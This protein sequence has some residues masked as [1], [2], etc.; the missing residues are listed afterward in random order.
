MFTIT[1]TLDD[2]QQDEELTT[3]S[4]EITDNNKNRT[5]RTNVNQQLKQNNSN[6]RTSEKQTTEKTK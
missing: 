5:D 6:T 4:T 3:V 2:V 1:F